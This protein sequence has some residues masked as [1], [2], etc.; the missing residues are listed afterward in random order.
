MLLRRRAWICLQ[1]LAL[2]SGPTIAEQA[3]PSPDSTPCPTETR[4][5]DGGSFAIAKDGTRIWY[6]TAGR[7]QDAPTIAY[8]H[9]GPG[10][11]AFVFEK[12]AGKRLE[13]RFRLIYLDQRGCG[14]SGFDGSAERYGMANTIDDIEQIR[15][16]VG[17]EHLILAAHSFGGLV[18]A[19]YANRFPARVSAIVMID[20]TPDISRA[21]S[22]QVSYL[23]SIAKTAYPD[24]A[25]AVHAI[26]GSDST[27]V[28][29]LTRLYGL[30]GRLPLQKQIQYARASNQERMEVLQRESALSSCTSGKVIQAFFKEG[31][32][33]GGVPAVVRR[34]AAPVL[35]IAGRRSHTIGEENI[36]YAS[37]IWG[38]RIEW[39]DAG[40]F[41]YFERPEE[42]AATL[43]R[44]VS[45]HTGW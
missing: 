19:E 40:H 42:F 28:E 6:K 41:V 23:D 3:P 12:S 7:Q 15:A 34:L 2:C 1:L 13:S 18:A 32:V 37:E 8:L 5:A 27:P 14:R 17:A 36:R 20:T 25:T 24:K 39:I 9:G 4:L 21:L 43:E 44:F 38:A 33:T 29:K 11:N 22:Y 35:L 26:A 45:E 31:Y 16:L 10:D 30:L